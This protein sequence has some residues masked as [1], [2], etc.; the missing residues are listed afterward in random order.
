MPITE[1][2]LADLRKRLREMLSERIGIESK[3]ESLNT[4]SAAIEKVLDCYG[5]GDKAK[6]AFPDEKV[7]SENLPRSVRQLTRPDAM[8]AA[9]KVLGKASPKQVAAKMTEMGWEW[10]GAKPVQTAGVELNRLSNMDNSHVQWVDR[11]LY[12]HV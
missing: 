12:R 4:E 7:L 8:R 6:R 9:L 3:L 2:T 5:D 11:G 1:E 10:N